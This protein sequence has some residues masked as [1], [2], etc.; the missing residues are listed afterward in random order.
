MR[1]ATIK[2]AARTGQKLQAEYAQPYREVPARGPGVI[3]AAGLPIGS[4]LIEAGH[5]HVLQARLGFSGAAWL[6]S[7]GETMS[8]LRVLRSNDRWSELWPLA[9]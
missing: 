5:K 9:A 2:H 4:G 1:S 6:P 3:I 7:N 8:Q